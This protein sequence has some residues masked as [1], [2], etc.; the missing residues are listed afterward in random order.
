MKEIGFAYEE[1]PMTGKSKFYKN[2][3]EVEFLTT[4]TRDYSSVYSVPEMG[5][6]A[7]CLKY[8]DITAANTIPVALAEG[9]LI[10]IPN[11]AA[12]VIQKAMI[13]NERSAAKAQ[14]D[15]TAVRGIVLSMLEE[16]RFK[17]DFA[18]IYRQ[19]GKKQKRRVDR[20][21]EENSIIELRNLIE[22]AEKYTLE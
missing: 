14:K 13:N 17:N 16:N 15:V 5:I 1:D 11:P 7:E 4:L 21:A 8:M 3:I 22:F 20:F 19:L 10:L 9:L 2:D 6:H 12:Y 18:R